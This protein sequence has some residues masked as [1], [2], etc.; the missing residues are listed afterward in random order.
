MNTFYLK[1]LILTLIFSLHNIAATLEQQVEHTRENIEFQHNRRRDMFNADVR[2]PDIAECSR[3]IDTILGNE[4]NVREVK[5]S[6][7]DLLK[8]QETILSAV[9]AKVFID[10]TGVPQKRG[11]S[12]YDKRGMELDSAR[13]RH[14]EIL[15]LTEDL[16][17]SFSAQVTKD[18]TFNRDILRRSIVGEY[19]QL[20][21]YSGL[22]HDVFLGWFETIFYAH[23]PGFVAKNPQY[24]GG[25]EH[26]AY[27][28]IP[29]RVVYGGL[30]DADEEAELQEALALSMQGQG[31]AVA[32]ASDVREE[33]AEGAAV[34]SSQE[35]INE[36]ARLLQWYKDEKSTQDFL[37]AEREAQER[38]AQERGAPVDL[39][40]VPFE[41]APYYLAPE[42]QPPYGVAEDDDLTTA[43]GASFQEAEDK[44]G[45]SIT[46]FPVPS[47]SIY[48]KTFEVT[49]RH[50]LAQVCDFEVETEEA[51]DNGDKLVYISGAVWKITNHGDFIGEFRG[52]SDPESMIAP[53]VVDTARQ[54]GSA[55]PAKPHIR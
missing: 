38:E 41:V 33:Y 2:N 21:T 20:F 17:D 26:R 28:P 43:L 52:N 25:R 13:H 34:F 23:C 1:I 3:S 24:G 53:T 11:I 5:M 15:R 32:V 27:S 40:L 10:Y 47:T 16:S 7:H 39:L 45:Q 42:A 12:I 19:E 8:H 4:R 46:I 44:A 55:I 9:M 31:A 29:G 51:T 49:V 48:A 6:K 36:Q 18:L 37:L 22:N 30:D 14:F 35:A 54:D 50:L